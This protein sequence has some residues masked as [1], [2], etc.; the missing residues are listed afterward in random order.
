MNEY[1]NVDVDTISYFELND[2]IKEL[3]NDTSC[4]YSIRPPN[5]V[6]IGD[7]N[8]DK[9]LLKTAKCLENEGIFEVYVHMANKESSSAFN[10][11]VGTIGRR[12]SQN[13]GDD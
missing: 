5:C 12:A 1:V 8:N 6:V 11:G 9:A 4:I 10:K 3:G 13:I 2:Y 7:I